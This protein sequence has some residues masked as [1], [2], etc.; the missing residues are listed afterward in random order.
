MNRSLSSAYPL[1]ECKDRAW[2]NAFGEWAI[3]LL[4]VKR[5]RALDDDEAKG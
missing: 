2:R 3:E 4:L 1:I 5:P